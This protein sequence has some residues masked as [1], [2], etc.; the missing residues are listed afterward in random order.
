MSRASLEQLDA[1]LTGEL[2]DAAADAV[3]AAMFDAPDDADLAFVDRFTRHGAQ[4]STRGTFHMGVTRKQL[5]AII[6]AGHEVQLVELPL[7]QRE[8]EIQLRG[9]LVV[10][11]LQLGRPDLDLV[12][13]EVTITAHGVSKTLRDV[14]VDPEDGAIYAACERALAE[15]AWGHGRVITRVLERGTHALLAELDV[16][17]SV[18][19]PR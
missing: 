3:E 10:T 18:V 9:D 5:D 7:D 16:V 4:L 11:R 2:D 13:V 15:L 17:A 19:A 8:I 14:R 6:A 1:Y 12:D